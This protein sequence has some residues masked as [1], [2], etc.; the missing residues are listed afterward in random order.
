MYEMREKDLKNL[1]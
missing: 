1:Y